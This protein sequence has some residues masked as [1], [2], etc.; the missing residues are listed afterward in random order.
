L[1]YDCTGGGLTSEV[2][3]GDVKMSLD[4][5]RKPRPA[6]TTVSQPYWA[7]LREHRLL[8]QRCADCRQLQFYPR[9]GCR[10]CGGTDLSWEQMSGSGRIYSYTVI[11]RAPFEAFAADVPY[12]YAIIQLDEGPRVV[13]TIE[14]G[15]HDGLVVDTPVTAIFDDGDDGITLLRFRPGEPAR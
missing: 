2:N 12:V 9:S 5:T 15:D 6:P 3:E 4:V 11:H 1:G 10:H 7:G 8:M 13:A 14:T